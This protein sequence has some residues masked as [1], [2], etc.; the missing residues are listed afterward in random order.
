MRLAYGGA[1]ALVYP[2]KYE[3]FG[4]PVLEAIS[5]GCPVITCPNAS[6]PEVAGDA[7][8]YINDNNVDELAEAL[9]EVQK[10]KVFQALI[11]AG[12]SQ[13]QKFSWS[14]MAN[15][16]SSALIEATLLNF[17]LKTLN[18]IVFPDWYCSE[19]SLLLELEEVVKA[20]ANHP[21]KGE[22]TLLVYLDKISEEEATLALSSVAMNLLMTEEVDVSEGPEI[23]LMGTLNHLQWEALKP[24][25]YGRIILEYENH[26]VI[27]FLNLSPIPGFDLNN[28]NSINYP[29]NK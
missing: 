14:K 5:C 11:T 2:S 22:I 15:I 1:I 13:A 3:G 20:I 28:F 6:I 21:Q 10:P 8:L 26:A 7:A 4:L 25:L 17:N 23:A 24:R 12:L 19:D 16:M 18:L 9:C 27:D 29:I